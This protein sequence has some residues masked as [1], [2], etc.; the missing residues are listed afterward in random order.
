M[1]HTP[2]A[3]RAGAGALL[4]RG[5]ANRSAVAAMKVSRPRRQMVEEP[6]PGWFPATSPRPAPRV[7]PAALPLIQGVNPPPLR[8]RIPERKASGSR[9]NVA[10]HRRARRSLLLVLSAYGEVNSL[11]PRRG[12]GARRPRQERRSAK[13]ARCGAAKPYSA[14]ALSSCLICVSPARRISFPT[15]ES[16]NTFVTRMTP[17][18]WGSPAMSLPVRGCLIPAP[19]R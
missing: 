15:K 18:S 4:P 17:S 5:P 10:S 2:A 7:R 13:G 11:F 12:L 14:I 8:A 9:K 6:P 3:N 19:S 16:F 1:N